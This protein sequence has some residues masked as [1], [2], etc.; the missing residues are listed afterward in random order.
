MG[1]MDNVSVFTKGLGE[2]AKGNYDVLA[3][4]NRISSAEKEMNGF[5][6]KLGKEYYKIHQDDP[7]DA[8]LEFVS[9]LKNT[10]RSIA[11][12]KQMVE[13][14]KAATSAVQLTGSRQSARNDS[15]SGLF[16]PECGSEIDEE[17]VFCTTCGTKIEHDINSDQVA[18]EADERRF[19]PE[20]GSEIDGDYPFCGVCGS[21]L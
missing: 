18:E 4:N 11:E 6:Q 9:E 13:E 3:L 2:K 17:T 20:C 12:L 8:L 16:C 21:R 5:F 15:S 1:F 7:E 14:T 19:C 10:E